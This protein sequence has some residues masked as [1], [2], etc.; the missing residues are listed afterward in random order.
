MIVGYGMPNKK[1]FF[2]HAVIPNIAFLI[3]RV[4]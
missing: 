2:I 3:E 1:V 4:V